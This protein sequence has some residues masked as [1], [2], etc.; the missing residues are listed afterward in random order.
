MKKSRRLPP[1]VYP[2]KRPGFTGAVVAVLLVALTTFFRLV[3][4]RYLTQLLFFTYFPAVM[5]AGWFG[6]FWP[7]VIATILSAACVNY[8]IV[9]Q[10]FAFSGNT[11]D[12]IRI[13]LFTGCGLFFSALNGALH[14]LLRNENAA[15]EEFEVTLASIG[16]AVIVAD[17]FG[18]ITFLNPVASHLTGW[19]LK[20]ALGQPLSTVAQIINDECALDRPK[21]VAD[22]SDRTAGIAAG[23]DRN[24]QL[25]FE[26]RCHPGSGKDSLLVSRS[27]SEIPI[28]ESVAPI[29]DPE[30][31]IVGRVLVLRNVAERR[32]AENELRDEKNKLEK[33]QEELRR[34][35][36]KLEKTVEERTAEL[37]ANLA[38]LE[39]FSYAISHDLRSPLRAMQG[40]ATAVLE[41]Y[42][43]KIDSNGRGHLEKI[44]KA[45]ERMDLLTRDVLAYSRLSTKGV[46]VQ[47]IQLE[48]LVNDILDQ[49]PNVRASHAELV[50]RT[51]L[52]NV[53]GNESLLTQA[54]GNLITNAV[55]F[56]PP[57]RTPKVEIWTES[58]AGQ[59]VRFFV[60]D[61]GIGIKPEHQ[62]KVFGLFERIHVHGSFEGTGI[63]LAIVRKVTERLGGTVG[64]ESDGENGSTFWIDLLAAKTEVPR[65]IDCFIVAS[66]NTTRPCHRE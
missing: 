52:Q 11:L 7:G 13:G 14:F 59:R 35:A 6:G 37:R 46:D 60:K 16:D 49:Y 20:D 30:G 24:A 36:N 17:A 32:R 21:P 26:V 44:I 12:L 39:E 3:L 58:R 66:Q 18:L 54:I 61:N 15:R 43:D 41:D 42:R 33:M 9:G 64:L 23:I 45:A 57:G 65:R 27:G 56:M 47:V 34:H 31:K 38:Q 4:A 50:V 10:G 55:K 53:M 19:D 51:P 22:A 28:E 25:Q 1:W 5:V 8:F 62:A 63:G 40:Y 2:S 48:A 29:K